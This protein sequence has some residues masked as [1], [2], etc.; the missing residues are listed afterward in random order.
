VFL[1]LGIV[2]YFSWSKEELQFF[3]VALELSRDV[4]GIGVE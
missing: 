4:L 2:D 1:L 3:K